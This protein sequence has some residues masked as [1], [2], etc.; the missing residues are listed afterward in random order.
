MST[1]STIIST[2]NDHIYYETSE[3]HV[4]FNNKYIGDTIVVSISKEN[5]MDIICND[6]FDLT[7]TLKP[8]TEIYNICVMYQ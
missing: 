8:S 5:I 2:S 6:E 1:K 4:D 7:F 3:A